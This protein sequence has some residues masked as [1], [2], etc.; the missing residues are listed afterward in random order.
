MCLVVV[1]AHGWRCCRPSYLSSLS[2]R[3]PLILDV[4]RLLPLLTPSVL[5]RWLSE[6]DVWP[7][8]VYTDAYKSSALVGGEKKLLGFCAPLVRRRAE[9]PLIGPAFNQKGTK[10]SPFVLLLGSP[11]SR[12]RIR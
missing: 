6:G 10:P 4:A 3:F 1:G 12:N 9:E 7:R 8:A 5:P 2:I 11:S